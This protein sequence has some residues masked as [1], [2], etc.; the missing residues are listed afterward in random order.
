MNFAQ[1]VRWQYI[2]AIG[3]LQPFYQQ[4]LLLLG[5]LYFQPP[6][7]SLYKGDA[8]MFDGDIVD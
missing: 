2:C 1:S 6:S 4:I 8:V 3:F 5:Q 7:I